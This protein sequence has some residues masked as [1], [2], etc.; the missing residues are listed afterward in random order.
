MALSRYAFSPVV[1]E[2]TI[3]SNAQIAARI[4]QAVEAGSLKTRATVLAE[5]QRLGHIAGSEYG[6]SNLWWI[7]AAAS[8]IGWA[9]QVPPGTLLRIPTDLGQIYGLIA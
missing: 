6:D 9:L 8:G 2:G 5:G 1:A 7:I 4:H 3:R